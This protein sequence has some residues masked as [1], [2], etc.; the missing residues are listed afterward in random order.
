LEILVMRSLVEFVRS[1]LALAIA[2]GALSAV[3]LSADTESKPAAELPPAAKSPVDFDRDIA[4][5]FDQHCVACHSAEKQ[6]GGLRLDSRDA[7]AGG[8]SGVVIEPK[9]S[10]DSLLVRLVA[11]LEPDKIMPPKGDR[12]TADQIGLL[13]AWID[14]GAKWPDAGPGESAVKSDHWAFQ[15]RR[16][17]P[18][19]N[20]KNSAAVR[21]PIDKF[22]LHRLERENISPAVEADKHTLIRRLS[23][24]LIGLPPTPAEVDEFV[25]DERPDAYERLVDR[26]LASPHFG[27]RWARHWLDQARYADSDGYEKDTGRPF[28]YRWRD[29]V[30]DAINRDLPFDQFT[31]E[32]LAGDLL[33]D[34]TLDQKI[35]TGFHRNTLTNKEGGVDQEEFRVKQIVDR[36]N[37][38]GTV[39]L[40]LTVGCAQCHSHKFD[41]LTQ[42][43]YYQLF[44]FF[45]SS[46]EVDLPA[47]LPGDAEKYAAAKQAFDAAHAK[48]VAA[49]TKHE[50]ELAAKQVEWEASA[51][52]EAGTEIAAIRAV[53]V[54]QRTEKQREQL[55]AHIRS[56][57]AGW[58][59]L[60]KA[61]DDHL[62]KAPKP[63]ESK[64]PTL[65]EPASKTRET[66]VLVRGDFLRPGT[67][68][69]PRTPAVLPPMSLVASVDAGTAAP[70]A[71]EDSPNSQPSTLDTPPSRLALAKWLVH[72]DHP[73]TARVTVNRIWLP[74]F[75]RGLVNTPDDFGT[76]GEQPSHPELLDWLASEFVEGSRVE[77]RESRESTND[78]A[79]RT[80]RLS[81]LDSRL[82]WSRKQL[83][84]LIVSSATYRQS[85][86]TRLELIDRDPQNVWLARQNRLRLEAE[87]IRDCALAVSGL[88]TP[89]VG[90]PSVRPPQP[91]GISELTYAGG[92]KWAESTGADRYRRGLYIWFQR[93]SPYPMLMT[94]DSP[95]GN[96]CT[97]KRERS[98][99]PLQALTLLNDTAFVECAQ[100]LGRRL[101]AAGVPPSGGEGP[102]KAGTPT[103]DRIRHAV[104]LCLNR[105]PTERELLLLAGLYEDLSQ[106]FATN[107]EAAAKLAGKSPPIGVAPQ[108]VAA[109]VAF[110]RTMLNLDEFYTRD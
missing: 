71:P 29:W 100:A 14:Q 98:N 39:W 64:V 7:L 63:D 41:P 99:T 37:T 70:C 19:P 57:D 60:K 25:R 10:A 48:L 38:T 9:Q 67:I 68:V 106:G 40:G 79:A 4:P 84:K 89:T 3:A 35:A 34:A 13:R 20:V 51:K 91:A 46:N 87:V 16:R 17:P 81:T 11:G 31:I 110:A 82:P 24:D 52:V 72:S 6:K 15:P 50:T 80:S 77:S 101:I 43:E 90:G 73:L 33:T 92:A 88:L 83:I 53:P 78:A 69:T 1:R 96:V 86:K 22:I 93:T 107:T 103:P 12:L 27:E 109:W 30:I 104:R 2:F 28:A 26:L 23:L 108:E 44:A 66:H 55:A 54:D 49:R 32:Q 97:V 58:I 62:K 85:S 42:R 75:G 56:Q 61:E 47:P 59:K 102:A 36:V 105:D 21:N 74:L 45:N 76:R 18:V 5:I 95:D 65:A 94:F 8:D